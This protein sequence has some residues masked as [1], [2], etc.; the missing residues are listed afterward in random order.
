MTPTF[1]YTQFKASH[2]TDNRVSTFSANEL[3]QNLRRN[4][5]STSFRLKKRYREGKIHINVR[6]A[7][8]PVVQT[9]NPENEAE[10]TWIL[11]NNGNPLHERSFA[12]K[13]RE[14]EEI[15]HFRR[16]IL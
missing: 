15:G 1:Y 13:M 14:V 3:Q 16:M 8:V 11:T 6:C 10:L 4:N 12:K 9:C 5:V 2:A 7:A